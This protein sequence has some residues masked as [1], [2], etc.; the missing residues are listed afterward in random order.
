[1]LFG[2]KKK[3]EN[4]IHSPY[5]KYVSE[6]IIPNISI[7]R[8]TVLDTANKCFP[9]G[10]GE[11]AVQNSLVNYG[12]SI[13][14]MM[15]LSIAVKIQNSLHYE[16]PDTAY[17]DCA[18]MAQFIMRLPLRKHEEATDDII[19]HWISAFET[20]VKYL[21]FAPDDTLNDI[22]ETGNDCYLRYEV[23][24]EA[25]MPA[26]YFFIL[27]KIIKQRQAGETRPYEMIDHTW[28]PD[29]NIMGVLES[30]WDDIEIMMNHWIEDVQTIQDL[31]CDNELEVWDWW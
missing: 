2:K 3:E 23:S 26:A 21:T 27:S 31:A 24:S 10:I 16:F 17:A 11:S 8:E 13:S 20:D 5:S 22:I 15:A 6:K 30:A 9:K 19:G 7:Q 28:T 25:K 1:M 29:M 18:L 14:Q 4:S 12:H